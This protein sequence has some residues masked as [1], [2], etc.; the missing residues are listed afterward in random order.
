MNYPRT[1]IFVDAQCPALSEGHIEIWAKP[2]KLLYIL[3]PLETK[4]HFEDLNEIKTIREHRSSHSSDAP[5]TH[6]LIQ[7]SPSSTLLYALSESIRD[8]I[9][10]KNQD[11]SDHATKLFQTIEDLES[12]RMAHLRLDA[13]SDD[14]IFSLEETA[15]EL[16]A[17]VE[18]NYDSLT[19]LT[20]EWLE[21][22]AASTKDLVDLFVDSTKLEMQKSAEENS[23][24][25]A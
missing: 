17:D 19:G 22:Y 15:N 24:K 14:L 6:I 13:A 25:A 11:A 2:A 21:S 1:H 7:G 5:E 9:H 4:P 3:S 16:D 18:I 20:E 23:R 10:I 8:V 12:L